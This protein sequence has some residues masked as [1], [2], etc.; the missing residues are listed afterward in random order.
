MLW[1]QANTGRLVQREKNR[2]L[3]LRIILRLMRFPIN[4]YSTLGVL[5][6]VFVEHVMFEV[7]ERREST[8]ASTAFD[9]SAT[10]RSRLWCSGELGKSVDDVAM[11][12]G[13]MAFEMV[14]NESAKSRVRRVAAKRA[15]E[16]HI[17]VES[18][19]MVSKPNW[20]VCDKITFRASTE[21]CRC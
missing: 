21:A 6:H 7:I 3:T 10:D 5:K 8:K 18:D 17:G 11:S 20:S 4:N 14:C 19:L 12:N 13:V 1:K 16:A 2:A 15:C 9:S